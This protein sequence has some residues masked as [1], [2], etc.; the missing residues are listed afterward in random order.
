MP[1][2]FLK[3]KRLQK[4]EILSTHSSHVKL[5]YV[6]GENLTKYTQTSSLLIRK[7]K[8]KK[9]KKK[10][11]KSVCSQDMTN[12]SKLLQFELLNVP[13]RGMGEIVHDMI[14]YQ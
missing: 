10:G 13:A 7:P 1:K 3:I 6:E 14:N 11:I 8:K 12:I 2:I 4:Y 5:S 9:K